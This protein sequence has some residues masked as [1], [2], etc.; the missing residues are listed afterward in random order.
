M[1]KY[2]YTPISKVRDLWELKSKSVVI[3]IT[4]LTSR[5]KCCTPKLTT[6]PWQ[7]DDAELFPLTHWTSIIDDIDWN[8]TLQAFPTIT[9]TLN[10]I[11]IKIVPHSF[12]N[13][14]LLSGIIA[15]LADC[16]LLK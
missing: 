13:N 11:Y 14:I 2:W 15:N 1:N 7:F 4:S 10:P 16:K 12:V 6:V 8:H 3:P 5:L 9:T